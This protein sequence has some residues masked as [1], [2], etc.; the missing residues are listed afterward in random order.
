M[1]ITMYCEVKQ[2]RTSGN[3]FIRAVEY[4][5]WPFDADHIMETDFAQ[6]WHREFFVGLKK[7]GDTVCF[8]IPNFFWLVS[9][10]NKTKVECVFRQH[11]SYKLPWNEN[12]ALS[13]VSGIL[14]LG[15]WYTCNQCS[16]QPQSIFVYC[17][18][19]FHFYDI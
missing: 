5:Q 19:L 14:T 6:N 9:S 4:Y 18:I 17:Y 10:H 12:I 15:V 13:F 2:G 8:Q 7:Y 11:W 3:G 16:P 1:Q